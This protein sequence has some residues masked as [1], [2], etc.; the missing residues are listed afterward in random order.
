MA[1]VTPYKA[2]SSLAATVQAMIELERVMDGISYDPNTGSMV[3][4]TPATQQAANDALNA[5][6]GG[7]LD[8]L[9][10][11]YALAPGVSL[12]RVQADAAITKV[13]AAINNYV[14]ATTIAVV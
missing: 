5:M 9:T 13:V 11:P 8:Q 10:F 3:A 14:K 4:A 12:S 7:V 1:T 6:V 2:F